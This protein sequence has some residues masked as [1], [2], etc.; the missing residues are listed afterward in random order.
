[1]AAVGW[2]GGG[3][4]E[5]KAGALF[6][7]GK[8]S[9][10]AAYLASK[11]EEL[12]CLITIF[13]PSNMSYMFHY[14]NLEWTGLQA[15]AMGVPQVKQGTT[16]VKEEELNDLNNA[17]LLAKEKFGIEC[18]Y[19]GALA[20]VYQKS[21]VEAVCS[22]LGLKCVSPLWNSDPESHLRKLIDEG[23]D[24]II[25]SVSAMG[26]D[27]VWLG[28]R[29]DSET[30][31]RLLSLARKY[32]F[33]AGL[34]GGEGETYVLDC[35]AFSK[36]VKILESKKVWNGDSGY[37]SILRAELVRKEVAASSQERG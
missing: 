22:R 13:P 6:S 16:G 35:P 36:Q 8:D 24:F 28:R 32:G 18:V 30:V 10:Y 34:E 21:R 4:A 5:V 20:S 17:L 9:T 26:L 11:R 31:D 3:E 29:V 33:H 15:E 37:L 7:G 23:F 25:T 14:P 19:T 1:M 27:E 2:I 12:A